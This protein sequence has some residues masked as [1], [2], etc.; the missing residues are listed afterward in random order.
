MLSAFTNT[1][2]ALANATMLHHPQQRA[3]T[4]LTVDASDLAVG[5]VLE[6]YSGG[7]WKP[8]AFFSRQLRKLETR[9]SAFDRELLALHLAIRHF[10]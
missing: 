3:P 2:Q 6:Q 1:K 9:Y 10:R 8:L 7:I 4:S 5:A